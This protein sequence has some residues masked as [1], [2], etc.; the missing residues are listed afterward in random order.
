MATVLLVGGFFRS[1]QFTAINAL[2]YSD[3]PQH[4]L[5]HATSL[6]S[7]L[8]Q[9]SVACGVAAAAGVLE[10]VRSGRADSTL[11]ASDFSTAFFIVAAIS[12]LAMFIPMGLP[13]NAGDS[14]SGHRQETAE[15]GV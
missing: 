2:G 12:A 8:Q 1:L 10:F 9:I 13:R 5:S 7:V 11:M 15:A 6:S 3:I 14:V 4:R